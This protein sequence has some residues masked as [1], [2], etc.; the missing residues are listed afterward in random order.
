MNASS[1][2]TLPRRF[3]VLGFLCCWASF[4][5][6]AQSK[7]AFTAKVP[8][9]IE[10]GLMFAD[11]II[12]GETYNFLIDTGAP[13]VLS[14]E[15]A[16]KVGFKSAFTGTMGSSNSLRG[17]SQMG[18][19]PKE[20]ELG[21]LKFSGLRVYVT[22]YNA[23]TQLIRCLDFDG[24]IGASMMNNSIWH[25]DYDQSQLLITNQL[26]NVPKINEAWK[27]K[28]KKVGSSKKPHINVKLGPRKVRRVLFD[29]G[30]SGF[31]DLPHFNYQK[32]R[33]SGK[34]RADYP[35]LAGYGT[36]SEGAFGAEDTTGFFVEA[37]SLTIGK[38]LMQEPIFE[39]SHTKSFKIGSE[40]LMGRLVTFDFMR[41][42]LYVFEKENSYVPLDSQGYLLSVTLEN[43][44]IQIAALFGE[45][46]MQEELQIGDQVM[47]VGDRSFDSAQACEDI[48]WFRNQL[49]ERTEPLQLTINRNGEIRQV[50]LIKR[51][52]FED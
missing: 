35:V 51:S 49:E 23:N 3:F 12:D 27:T 45:M 32:D 46:L 9:R 52:L 33:Q 39:M 10:M 30:Y 18:T 44:T 4:S 6:Y 17:S 15:L 1:T 40:Y 8:L 50:T 24:I 11:V 28:M 43:S 37:P 48:L 13:L 31:F 29:T 20:I 26:K 47:A 22:D 34:I 42:K 5:L 25:F 14:P 19:I 16:E 7:E 21:G 2:L 36:M 41:E 38:E